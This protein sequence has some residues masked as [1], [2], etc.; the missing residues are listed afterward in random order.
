MGKY[1]L[2]VAGQV[3]ASVY[4]KGFQLERRFIS[5]GLGRSRTRELDA[6]GRIW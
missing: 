5:K 4:V 3:K 1:T 6:G 2:L